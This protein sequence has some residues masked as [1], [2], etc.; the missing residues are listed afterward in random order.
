MTI[1]PV[2]RVTTS[3]NMIVLLWGFTML[4]GHI[5]LSDFILLRKRMNSLIALF[6]CK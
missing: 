5:D 2:R 6:N 4:Q 3:A 1:N